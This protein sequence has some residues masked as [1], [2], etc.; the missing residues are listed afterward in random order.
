MEVYRREK[1]GI[2]NSWTAMAAA[3]EVRTAVISAALYD[4]LS[5]YLAFRHVVRQSY[6]FHLQWEKM[7][8]LVLNTEA[9]MRSVEDELR[10]FLEGQ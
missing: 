2:V 5:E 8:A 6:S 4:T 3:N 10:V 9:T 7:A 1:P